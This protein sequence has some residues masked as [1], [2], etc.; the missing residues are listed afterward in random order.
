MRG[1]MLAVVGYNSVIS[2]L[3]RSMPTL[4]QSFSR[5]S[6]GLH[7][8]LITGMNSGIS[9]ISW[10]IQD[11]SELIMYYNVMLMLKKEVLN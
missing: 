2:S 6:A 5:S 10:K 7:C 11:Q 4:H 8:C 3:Y 9:A 1:E